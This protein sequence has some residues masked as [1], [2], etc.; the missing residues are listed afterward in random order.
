M[1]IG[2]MAVVSA[3]AML[4]GCSQSEADQRASLKSQYVDRCKQ[5][6]G[7]MQNPSVDKNKYCECNGAKISEGFSKEEIAAISSEGDVN[8]ARFQSVV[9]KAGL[10]CLQEQGLQPGPA[11][12]AP[13]PAAVGGAE[14]G[15]PAEEPEAAAEEV[16]E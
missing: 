3:A 8:P 2:L 6:S 16:E 11:A 4:A 10:Q 5:R 15:A 7:E 14:A 13:T 9:E 12:T 1:R